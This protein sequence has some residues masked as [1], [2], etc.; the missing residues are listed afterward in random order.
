M[1]NMLKNRY[2]GQDAGSMKANIEKKEE[3]A[4]NRMDGELAIPAERK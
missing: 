2:E 4:Y 1:E 3:M